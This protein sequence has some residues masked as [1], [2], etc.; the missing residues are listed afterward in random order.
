MYPDNVCKFNFN[1]SSDLICTNFVRERNNSQAKESRAGGYFLGIVIGGEGVLCV[2]K[3]EYRLAEGSL[4]F[5]C[6]GDAFSV[7]SDGQFE[8]CYI[9]F[10]GRRATE[11][12]ERFG[13]SELRC[14]FEGHSPLVAFWNESQGLADQGNIDIVCEAVLLYSLAKLKPP[15]SDSNDDVISKVITLTQQHF[16]ESRVSVAWVAD[17]VGYD[18]KYISSLFKRRTGVPYTHFLRELRVK[19]ALFLI[20]QGVVSVKNLAVLSGFSD[21]LYFSKVFSA[22]VGIPPRDYIRKMAREKEIGIEEE[23]DAE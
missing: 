2:N 15:K 22:A 8:Y 4:F 17:S 10:V 14:V 3:R 11:Y 21:P 9:T 23:A 18:V 7:S 13:I 20:E 19:H 1:R 16:T 12:I 6:E 5:V